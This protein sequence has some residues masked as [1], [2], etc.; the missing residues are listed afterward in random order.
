MQDG[1]TLRMKIL[2]DSNIGLFCV[3]TE[4]F[5]LAPRTVADKQLSDMEKVLG[6]PVRRISIGYTH[7]LGAFSAANKNGVV[8]SNVIEDDEKK[9][10]E[11]SLGV[12]VCVLDSRFN[13]LGNLISTNDKGAIISPLFGEKQKKMIED[14]LGVET[15]KATMAGTPLIGSGCLSNNN[16]AFLHRDVKDN[17]KEIIEGVLKVK[18]TAGT[19]G[20]GS[21]WVGAVAICNSRGMV[22]DKNT[23]VHE[24]V[25]AAGTLGFA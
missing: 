24:I 1:H 13:T 19:L 11:R 21:P 18:A 17:E 12:S 6:V 22:T 8:V 25:R 7:F 15:V 23:T 20:F 5:C 2:G 9:T 10:L 16:G 3:A 14:C 4:K